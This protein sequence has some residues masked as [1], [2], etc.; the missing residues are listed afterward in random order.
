MFFILCVHTYTN[1]HPECCTCT[2]CMTVCVAQD[3]IHIHIHVN[4]HTHT[5]TTPCRASSLLPKAKLIAILHDP[6][7]RAYSWYQHVR[8]HND[9]T[10]FKYNFSEV[11]R[12]TPQSS[13]DRKLLSL[14]DH[15]LMPGRYQIHLSKWLKYY[16]YKQLYLVDGGELVDDPATVME[17]V[18]EFLL[19]DKMMNYSNILRFVCTCNS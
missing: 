17:R 4:T 13:H 5:H 6:I 2:H 8:A 18:Q 11:I 7:R 19:V 9:P 16:S 12:A 10:A 1:I 14:R 15:C 3:H